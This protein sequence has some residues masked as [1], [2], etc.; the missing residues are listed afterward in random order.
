M[1]FRTLLIF[2]LAFFT[3]SFSANAQN[4]LLSDVKAERGK[5]CALMTP[6]E[7]GQLLNAVAWNNRADGWML[8]GKT[9]G[10]N[11]PAP[12]GVLISCDFLAH[13]PTLLGYDV[14][15]GA[16]ANGAPTNPKARWSDPHSL[17][18]DLNNGSRTLVPAV[19]PSGPGGS[20]RDCNEPPPRPNP[21]PQPPGPEPRPPI[22]PQPNSNPPEIIG[23]D[24]NEA[25]PGEKI[26]I[27]GLYLTE[28][29][30]IS[31]AEGGENHELTAS[32]NSQKTIAEITLPPDV[33]PG[34]YFVSVIGQTGTA[35]A[36]NLFTVS[37]KNQGIQ[38]FQIPAIKDFG[39]LIE[40]IFQWGLW[41][42]GAAVF[43]NFL[44]AGFL[45]FTA[46][47]RPGPIGQAKEKMTNALIGAIILLASY[48][49]LKTINPDLVQQVFTLPGL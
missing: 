35:V 24:P 20:Q 40:A 49:I 27:I 5:Y 2:G 3:L 44:W 16:S 43:V 12:S 29:V 11:C 1:K 4:S 38:S 42:V 8:Y 18:R 25:K 28:K 7:I 31:L 22:L 37:E 46:A 17:T 36:P 34:R 23:A 48:L 32:L 30:M 13:Q 47:G 41:L 45:W 21:N 26:K 6:S 15:T 14:L 19:Q 39:D 33:S 10:Q 9:I